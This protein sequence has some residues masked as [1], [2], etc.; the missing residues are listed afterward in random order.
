[1]NKFQ[2]ILAAT[3]LSPRAGFAI[4][5]AAL[6]ARAQGA[7]LDLLHV[8]GRLPLE[9]IR[10]IF[11]EHPL[12]TEQRLLE[13][14]REQLAGLGGAVLAKH[15]MNPASHVA[16]GAVADEIAEHG[17]RNSVDL[18]A[19]G[20]HG[21]N[22][23]QE[24]LLG[25]TAERIVRSGRG[26]HLVVKREPTRDYARVVV[27]VDF[28]PASRLALDCARRIAG[29]AILHVLHVYEVPFESKMRYAG[30]SE[31]DFEHYRGLARREAEE[32]LEAFLRSVPDVP[33]S[34]MRSVQY[35]YAPAA[36]LQHARD[37]DADLVAMGGQGRSALSYALMGSV[38]LHVLRQSS[39]D[40]LV[41]KPISDGAAE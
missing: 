23:V 39:C 33:R 25:T 3:D 28:S 11:V 30:V 27:P 34:L 9:A 24:L 4:E 5:R 21:E 12:E 32:G 1:M 31:A 17:K 8:V 15:G 37:M 38:S 36:I 40:V 6:L 29:E 2:K 10:R 13:A 7:G 16:V 18:V 26:P 22:F 20:A 14:A 19:L 41:V 35:G